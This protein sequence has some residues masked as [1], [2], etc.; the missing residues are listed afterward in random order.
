MYDKIRIFYVHGMGGGTDSR[1]PS[2]LAE[3][4]RTHS[5]IFNGRPVSVEVFVD[6]YEFDP[7]KAF[8]QIQQWAADFRPHLIIGESLGASHAMAVTGVPH[9]YVSPA[10][11]APVYFSRYSWTSKIPGVVP[12]LNRFF[13]P[14]RPGRQQMDFRGSVTR[15][16]ADVHRR[17]LGNARRDYSFAFFGERDHYRKWGVVDVGQWGEIYGDYTTYPGTHF[18]EM[19]FLDTMLIPKINEVLGLCPAV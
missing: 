4:Y 6:T 8:C 11:N 10:M 7:D 2:V 13:R 19:E 17:A 14:T 1:I 5:Y 16:Y 15:R 3:H 12:F 9:L 18:M